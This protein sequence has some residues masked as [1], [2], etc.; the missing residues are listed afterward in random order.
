MRA[1]K[2][3]YNES[4]GMS[5]SWDDGE[6]TKV[7]IAEVIEYLEDTNAP[8]REVAL[9]IIRP[10]IIDQNYKGKNSARIHSA[11]LDYPIIVISQSGKLKSILDGNHRAM[12]AID[13]GF[14][15]IKVQEIDLD[16]ASLPDRFKSLFDFEINPLYK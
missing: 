16:S 1:F 6:G 12:K 15:T 9:D 4:R 5:T 13:K 8:V 2:E 3:Y 14:G 11:N 7:S 10:L